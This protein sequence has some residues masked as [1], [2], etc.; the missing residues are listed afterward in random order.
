MSCEIS[1]Q[2]VGLWYVELPNGNWLASINR[3]TDG[4]VQLDYR[5]RWFRDD[6]LFDESNDVRNWYR[7]KTNDEKKLLET[8]RAIFSQLTETFKGWEL[9]RGGRSVEEF[10]DELGRMPGMHMKRVT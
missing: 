7:L 9:M 1:E 2:T 5:L 4:T 8:T 3:I 10:L 6:K